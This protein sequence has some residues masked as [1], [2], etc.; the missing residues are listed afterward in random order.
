ML[1]STSKGYPP[2]LFSEV[3]HIFQYSNIPSTHDYIWFSGKV[4]L[5]GFAVYQTAA[6]CYYLKY[7]RPAMLA[8]RRE[9][10]DFRLALTPMLVAER[11]R[12]YIKH[13]KEQV[14]AEEDLMKDVEGWEVGTWYGEKVYKTCPDRL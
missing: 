10:M 5:A 13:L 4:I 12:G 6:V 2:G 7:L 14:K 8:R 9:A 1:P 3:K 11:D